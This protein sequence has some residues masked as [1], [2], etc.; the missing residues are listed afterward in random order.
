[1]IPVYQHTF[2]L[3]DYTGTIYMVWYFGFVWYIGYAYAC[4]IYDMYDIYIELS[5]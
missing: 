2:D 5:A 4:R 1:M 3:Y